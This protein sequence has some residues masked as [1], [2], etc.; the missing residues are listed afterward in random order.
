MNCVRVAGA[1][2]SV[3]KEKKQNVSLE[4]ERDQMVR[5]YVRLRSR[6]CVLRT[7]R[8]AEGFKLEN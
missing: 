6:D 3:I 5:G 1:K 8:I 7:S 4:C 2:A